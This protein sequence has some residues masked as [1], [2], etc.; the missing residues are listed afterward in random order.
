MRMSLAWNVRAPIEAVFH[1]YADPARMAAEVA[2]KSR[3][4]VEPD[5]ELHEGTV[6][7]LRGPG[8]KSSFFFEVLS[9]EFPTRMEMRGWPQEHPERAAAAIY[10]F[11]EVDGG[12][13]VTGVMETHL[14]PGLEFGMLLLRPLLAIGAR[15]GNRKAVRLIEEH[16]RAGRLS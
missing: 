4:S 10:E 2:P 16:Y 7:T 9:Y 8:I 12:T 14:R 11:A 15:R 3:V 13:R 6:L 1:Y 5:G